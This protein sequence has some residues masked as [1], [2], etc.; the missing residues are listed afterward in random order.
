MGK[1][2]LYLQP[3]LLIIL[4]LGFASGLPLALTAS[5]LTAWL[6]EEGLTLAS[7]GLFAAVA[8]PY[9]LKFLWSP[10]ID[11]LRLPVLSQLLGRR[12]GWL[13]VFQLAL[14]LAILGMSQI[15]PASALLLLAIVS[16]IVAFLSASQDIVIDALR[17]EMLEEH[18]QGAG[19]AMSVFGYR[20]GMIFSTA[21]ALYL[22]AV[23]GWHITY[24][25]MALGL[26]VGVVATLLAREPS[27]EMRTQSEDNAKKWLITYVAQPFHEFVQ[28]PHWW[29]ILLFILLFKL[30]EAMLGF[31]TMPFLL[32]LGFTKIEIATLVKLV[33]IAATIVGGFIG[34]YLVHRIGILRTLWIGACIQAVTNL[35]YLWLTYTGTDSQALAITIA[36]DS[37]SGGVG[38][39]AFVAYLSA[40]CNRRFTATQYALLNSFASVGRS[41]LTAPSGFMAE[42]MGWPLFFI[43]TTLLALPALW[44]LWILQK[45]SV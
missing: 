28:R 5:T 8:I 25:C 34:G 43:T 10:L 11:G 13:L 4:C 38:T 39:T 31:M 7:I 3:R 24:I 6:T 33:G 44:L 41:F 27:V 30:G 22:A 42:A 2:L 35:L 45:K 40:L 15:P 36:I 12:R 18:E 19:A 20:M 17:I 9:S 26:L 16:V 32:Q 37:F 14:I 23:Y 21:G 29:L 1:Y